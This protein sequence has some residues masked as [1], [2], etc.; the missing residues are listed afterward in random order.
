MPDTKISTREAIMLILSIIVA[1]TIVTLPATILK[2]SESGAILNLIYVS[3]LALL[4]VYLIYVLFKKFQGQDIFDI[5]E[6]L[7]GKFLKNVIGI[8]FIF[9]FI[10]S[11]GILLRNFAEGL[12]VIY[13]PNTNI[14]FIILSF[15]ITICITN[16][17]TFKSNVKVISIILPFVIISIIFLF[18]G[19]LKQFDFERIFPILGNSI[20]D[21]FITGIGNIIAFGGISCL[22]ILPPLLQKPE[23]FKK[24]ALTSIGISAIYLLICIS[25]IL[26]MFSFFLNVDEILPLYTA[27]SYIEY[28]AFF[29]RL[30]SLFLMIWMLEICCYLTIT[31]QFSAII[32]KK[33]TNLKYQKPLTFIFP[34]LIF[35]VALIPKTVAITRFLGDTLYKYLA[36]TIVF[37][38]GILILVI[39]N[40]K[41]KQE[42]IK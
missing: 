41:K 14:L 16:S 6:Y 8:I 29:Q 13:F 42:K 2:N 37:I 3:I 31:S 32:F 5:S 12:K 1:H 4:V 36:L 26:F 28:G 22:Y 20:Y 27:A 11:S 17:L 18:I 38:I 25:T 35:T 23:D 30:D 40:I 19:N 10:S 21:T 39:A 24:I 15:I 33:M 9:Y 34:I 7:G